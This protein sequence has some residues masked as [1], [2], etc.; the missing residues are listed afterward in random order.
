MKMSS[1]SRILLLFFSVNFCNTAFAQFTQYL[2]TNPI[3]FLKPFGVLEQEKRAKKYHIRSVTLTDHKGKLSKKDTVFEV[4]R[5]V[6]TMT[7]TTSGNI[8]AD[9]SGGQTTNYYYD[10]NDLLY[11]IN[12][13]KRDSILF[14]YDI[15]KKLV[16]QRHYYKD[17]SLFWSTTFEYDKTGKLLGYVV[18]RVNNANIKPAV[19]DSSYC[20][21]YHWTYDKD[22]RVLQ[23]KFDTQGDPFPSGIYNYEYLENGNTKISELTSLKFEIC[24]DSLGHEVSWRSFEEASKM[25]DSDYQHDKDG[26]L[27]LQTYPFYPNGEPIVK[28]V[29]KFNPDGLIIEY[30]ET[31][32]R[33]PE[34]V[35][36]WKLSYTFY[37]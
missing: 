33:L 19:R 20:G 8:L 4:P 36:I 29:N 14:S 23:V 6:Y 21:F 28:H 18:Y 35:R 37:K 24:F 34:E 7:F 15:N 2:S 25:F 9:N 27:L 11:K 32:S 30:I 16:H 5:N 12:F 10:E 1:F 31:N 22:G 13:G 26:N 3:D 17:T